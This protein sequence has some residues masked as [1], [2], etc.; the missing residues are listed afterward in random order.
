MYGQIVAW[1]V[2]SQNA[3]ATNPLPASTLDSR[4]TSAS[5]TLGSG[6]VASDAGSTFGGSGFGQTSLAEAIS[7]GDYLSFSLT[8]ASGS[9]FSLSSMSLLFGVATATVTTNFNVALTS[10]ASGFTAGNALW[11]F[12][13]GTASPGVQTITLSSFPSL[14]DL[15]LVVEFRLYGWRDVSGTTTFRIRSNSGNDLSVFGT[16]SAIPEP[17][18]YAALMGAVVLALAAGARW[19]KPRR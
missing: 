16:V 13:F 4:F 7:G 5:L 6:V 11:N 19:T 15:T 1:D 3:A 12:A 14:Q 10:S 9:T 2:S 8:P 18:T 17:S